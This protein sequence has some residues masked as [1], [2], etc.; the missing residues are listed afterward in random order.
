MNARGHSV[1]FLSRRETAGPAVA[2]WR[3][4]IYQPDSVSSAYKG[5]SS[6]ARPKLK[7]AMVYP[8]RVHCSMVL[9]ASLLGQMDRRARTRGCDSLLLG[10]LVE[11][12]H[13]RVAG[14]LDQL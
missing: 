6:Q 8:S 2:P 5:F 4:A 7:T 14:V 10:R 11:L 12:R 9:V 3:E 1:M 13:R